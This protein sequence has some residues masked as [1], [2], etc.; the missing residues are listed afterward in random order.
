MHRSS[1]RFLFEDT[2]SDVTEPEKSPQ[3]STLDSEIEHISALYSATKNELIAAQDLNE[4]MV[5]LEEALIQTRKLFKELAQNNETH[6]YVT[7]VDLIRSKK[8]QVRKLEHDVAQSRANLKQATKATGQLARD[9]LC[10][11]IDKEVAKLH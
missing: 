9:S 7:L 3:S 4:K 10:A 1:F 2:P 6:D 5:K 11:T 8:A